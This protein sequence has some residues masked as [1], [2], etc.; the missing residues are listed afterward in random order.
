MKRSTINIKN[1]PI[2]ASTNPR[3]GW[4]VILGF[5]VTALLLVLMSIE[6]GGTFAPFF[7]TAVSGTWRNEASAE[8]AALGMVTVR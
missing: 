1:A 8:I 4:A 7:A 6:D 5:F 2:L 3:I